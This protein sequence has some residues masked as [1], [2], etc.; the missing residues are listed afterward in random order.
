M[1]VAIVIVCMLGLAIW[2]SFD[3][4]EPFIFVLGLLITA[5]IG[6][7][8]FMIT[9][10]FYYPNQ[11]TTTHKLEKLSTGSYVQVADNTYTFKIDDKVI[12]KNKDDLDLTIL[13]DGAK[14]K[15]KVTEDPGGFNQIG[16]EFEY[17]GYELRIPS[18]EVEKVS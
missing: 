6:F 3:D 7:L 2:L 18:N 12:V 10:L 16:Y 4:G 11:N 9:G 17:E 15:V 5:L 8:L 13:G 14:A 1:L